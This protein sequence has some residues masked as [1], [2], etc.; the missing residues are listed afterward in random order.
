MLD[1]Q[2]AETYLGGSIVDTDIHV[3]RDVAPNKVT[4]MFLQILFSA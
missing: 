1:V 3:V 2:K 4:R